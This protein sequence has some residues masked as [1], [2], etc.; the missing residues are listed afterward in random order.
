MDIG[1]RVRW[2]TPGGANGE[3][4]VISNSD[5]DA[6]VAIKVDSPDGEPH[7]ILIFSVSSL[8]VIEE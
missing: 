3:G 1:T 7:I 4:T 5:A 8:V 2:N 6:E